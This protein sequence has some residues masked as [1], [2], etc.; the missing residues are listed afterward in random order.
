MSSSEV[1]LSILEFLIFTL[2]DPATGSIRVGCI[3]VRNLFNY[4][5]FT[6]SV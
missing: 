1:L 5:L 6:L 2:S 4:G 3:K